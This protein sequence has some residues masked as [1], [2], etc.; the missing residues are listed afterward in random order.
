MWYKIKEGSSCWLSRRRGVCSATSS[1]TWTTWI[2]PFFPFRCGRQPSLE[3]YG[4]LWRAYSSGQ[5]KN[6]TTISGIHVY[7]HVLCWIGQGE[8]E[9]KGWIHPCN[10]EIPQHRTN[11]SDS[12]YFGGFASMHQIRIVLQRQTPANKIWPCWTEAL[13]PSGVLGGENYFWLHWRFSFS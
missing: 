5:R 12:L 4:G 13:N 11:H 9:Q 6:Q 3:S 10:I 7:M 1:F 2:W 8:M